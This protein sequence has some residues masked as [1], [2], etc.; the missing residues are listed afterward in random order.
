[1]ALAFNYVSSGAVDINPGANSAI[2]NS[3]GVSLNAVATSTI[4]GLVNVHL[5][6][7][8]CRNYDKIPAGIGRDLLAGIGYI[9]DRGIGKCH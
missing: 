7:E 9:S 1:M 4:S 8:L 2:L 3:I 5:K 6:E